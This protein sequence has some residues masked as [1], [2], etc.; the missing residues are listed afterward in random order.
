M[1]KNKYYYVLILLNT[2]GRLLAQTIW[3]NRSL[4]IHEVWL[5]YE[6]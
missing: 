6:T 2:T 1:L 4:R 5:Y 3:S